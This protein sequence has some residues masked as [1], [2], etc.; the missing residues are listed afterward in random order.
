MLNLKNINGK[1]FLTNLGPVEQNLS[2]EYSHCHD[3]LTFESENCH[4]T[5][6]VNGSDN[7]LT[8][9]M[10]L[11]IY[12]C[13]DKLFNNFIKNNSCFS[14][15]IVEKDRRIIKIGLNVG[16]AKMAELVITKIINIHNSK[17]RL[18]FNSNDLF[19]NRVF[20]EQNRISLSQI[21]FLKQFYQELV[22]IEKRQKKFSYRKKITN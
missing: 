16:E 19:F 2:F 5:I 17:I 8:E 21:K 13:I 15:V 1:L 12:R 7:G 4:A 6:N 20:V 22:E 10:E 14:N 3:F 9:E 18:E 11:E